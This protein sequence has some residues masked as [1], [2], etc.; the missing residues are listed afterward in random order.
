MKDNVNRYLK[1]IKILFPIYQKEE[2]EYFNRI[3]ENILKETNNE[4]ITYNQ[5]VEKF[6]TPT[7]VMNSYFEEMDSQ[8]LISKIRKQKITKRIIYMIGIVCILCIIIVSLWKIHIYNQAYE[9]F[10][11]QNFYYE[12]TIEEVD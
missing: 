4:D 3:K 8:K 12:E 5:C 11:K 10:Q 6:G 9:E 7:E 2:K 1:D